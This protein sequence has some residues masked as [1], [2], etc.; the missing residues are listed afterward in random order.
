MRRR[1]LA[2][3]VWLMALIMPTCYGLAGPV[4]FMFGPS[5]EWRSLSFP[6][7]KAAEFKAGTAGT[8]VVQADSA[9][10]VLWHPIPAALSR[11]SS[12]QW[13]WRVT[14]GVGPTDLTKKGGDDRSLAIYFVF[15]DGRETVGTVD[16]Q[17]LLRRGEG[18][19]LM[20]V[21]GDSISPGSILPFP[22]FDGR[23]RTIIKR[24]ADAP[25]GVWFK[26][27]ADVRGDFNSAFGRAPGRL[28]A[29]AVSGDSDDTRARIIA[30]VSD[31]V[32]K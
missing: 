15:A 12:A 25:L 31:L 20:Y 32:V 5:N 7:R 10:G 3:V 4:A 11:A 21:W 1:R 16:L 14:A 30:A 19:L 6:G 29:V 28:V 2:A 17:Q 26:E 18:F 23:G 9:V 27:T 24:T 22:Y 13:R 8:V